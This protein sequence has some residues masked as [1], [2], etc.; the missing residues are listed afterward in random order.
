[1]TVRMLRKEAK[2]AA[3]AIAIV[4]AVVGIA[5]GAAGFLLMGFL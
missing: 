5:L 3:V 1:M 2:L 4:A